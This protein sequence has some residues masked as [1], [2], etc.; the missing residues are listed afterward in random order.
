MK[1]EERIIVFLDILGFKSL[2]NSTV[3]LATDEDNEEVIDKIININNILTQ[4]FEPELEK[5]D[6]AK[7]F[8]AK[9]KKVS[10]F[11]DTLVITYKIDEKDEVF[12]TFVDI[13]YLIAELISI[14]I[15]VRGAITRGKVI[16]DNKMIF[17]PGLIK[18]YEMELSE[19]VY[20]RVILQE[21][22]LEL[23]FI[24]KSE[25]TNE[26]IAGQLSSILALDT[27]G[28]IYVDYFKSIAEAFDDPEIDYSLYLNK[29]TRVIKEGLNSNDEKKLIKFRWMQEKY[30]ETV[31]EFTDPYYIKTFKKI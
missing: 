5:S 31:S 12:F 4:A 9:S 7:E 20:P 24:F 23:P 17:G 27:D 10:Q 25:N 19:A 2:I 28:K 8:L 29:L 1:Y 15:L 22:V 21:N 11:S 13:Q 14:D 16:H 30:N 6:G 18:A 26:Y 3:N